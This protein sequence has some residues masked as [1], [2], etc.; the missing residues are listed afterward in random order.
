MKLNDDSTHR[1]LRRQYL[2]GLK[3]SHVGVAGTLPAVGDEARAAPDLTVSPSGAAQLLSWL[4]PQKAV[5][6][7]PQSSSD[8]DLA[9]EPEA[10]P[11]LAPTSLDTNGISDE[12]PTE[13]RAPCGK[14]ISLSCLHCG[15]VHRIW[16]R[17]ENRVR[18]PDC[19]KQ[20]SRD[21]QKRF[22]PV[23]EAMQASG[24]YVRFMTLTVKNGSDLAERVKHLERSFRKFKQRKFW[25]GNVDGA[26][27][28]LEITRSADG[29]HPHYHIVFVGRF[30]PQAKLQEQWEEITG[31]SRIVDVRQA[32]STV[33]K[34][35]FKYTVKDADL[36]PGDLDD[37]ERVLRNKNVVVVLGKFYRRQVMKR[38]SNP[39]KCESCGSTAFWLDGLPIE[40]WTIDSPFAIGP[41]G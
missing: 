17:C 34:E 16:K 10:L 12:L 38:E 24:Q 40:T 30:I 23:L 3:Q 6:S 27:R 33:L 26:I 28:V 19:R 41:P 25:K 1:H 31:D 4:R 21:S 2:S 39:L 20:W 14:Y 8:R 15:K 9:C 36:Q 5:P 11:D 35:L 13:E 37:V 32:S 22:K 29:W 18:C 7:N